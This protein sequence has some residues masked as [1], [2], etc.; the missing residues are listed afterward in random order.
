MNELNR[1]RGYL[2]KENTTGGDNIKGQMEMKYFIL[3]T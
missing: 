3:G 1:I 2:I